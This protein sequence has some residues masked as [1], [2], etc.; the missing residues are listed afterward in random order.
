MGGGNLKCALHLNSPL[1][2]AR[3]HEPARARYY[4]PVIGA[5]AASGQPGQEAED[6]GQTCEHISAGQYLV[7]AGQ[8]IAPMQLVA[9]RY[10][11]C[12]C[13]C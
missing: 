2:D 7:L 8:N 10:V 5:R 9:G 11:L 3:R 4:C 13:V 12:C 1:V 6:A